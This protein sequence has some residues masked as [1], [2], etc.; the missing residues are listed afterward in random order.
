MASEVAA[1]VVKLL[2]LVVVCVATLTGG[3]DDEGEGQGCVVD[4]VSTARTH[5]AKTTAALQLEATGA[6]SGL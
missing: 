2:A 1:L 3:A 4:I 6:A 5:Y